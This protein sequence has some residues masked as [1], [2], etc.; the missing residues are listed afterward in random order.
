MK[1]RIG[2][3]VLVA[4]LAA[5]AP[6][7]SQVIGQSGA[8]RG[9]VHDRDFDVPLSRARVTL[10]E[11]LLA[12]GTNADGQFLFERVPP[13]TYTLDGHWRDFAF[14]GLPIPAARCI[15]RPPK[16]TGAYWFRL[17]TRDTG[18][19]SRKPGWPR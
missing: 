11:A 19:M 16:K 15:L 13:G 18:G 5:I 10:V 7:S 8:I 14:R 12:T 6:A 1:C 3:T 17:L 4:V 2:A 9:S